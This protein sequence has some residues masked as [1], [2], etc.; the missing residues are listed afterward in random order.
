MVLQEAREKI[1]LVRKKLLHMQ[2][3]TSFMTL[4][5]VENVVESW[6]G[7][8][9]PK[10]NSELH[11]CWEE[12]QK[13]VPPGFSID[14]NLVRHLSFNE[15]K[16]WL[17]IS[18]SDIPR[19]LLNVEEYIKK[20]TLIEYLSTLHP[21]VSRVTE[22]ILNGDIDA[23]LKTVFAN[24][25]VKIRSV[26]RVGPGIQ[27]VNAIGEAFKKGRLKAYNNDAARNFLQGVIGYYRNVIIHHPL[28][29]NRNKIETA[30]SLFALAHEAFKLFDVCSQ[31]IPRSS[32]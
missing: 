13:S 30:L 29:P 19:E 26:L 7:N 2:E 16:D 6:M 15:A 25:D 14:S 17:D 8:E 10:E 1:E 4:D 32:S 22:I 18:N 11:S 20:L 28:S 21:E 12:I 9:Y 23:A 31:S 5:V 24:L 3:I 27:T